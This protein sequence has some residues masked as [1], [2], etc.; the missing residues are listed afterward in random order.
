MNWV[1]IG[2]VNGL[3]P[4]WR[5]AITWTNTDLLSIRPFRTI[6]AEIRIKI[7][8][9]SFTKMN[10]KMSSAKL[11]TFLPGGDQLKQLDNFVITKL[12][13]LLPGIPFHLHVILYQTSSL[14]QPAT[15]SCCRLSQWDTTLHCS[16]TSHWLSPYPEW[17]L[18]SGA[19][20]LY[21]QNG[22]M[23]FPGKSPKG[24]YGVP[25]GH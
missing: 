15:I 3:P 20:V 16:V 19:R 14:L 4:V 13:S 25:L 10:V 23:S 7:Q 9:F 21:R 11:W 1:G 12:F 17:P 2:S 5:Q 18:C 22:S 8:N 6:I 24:C